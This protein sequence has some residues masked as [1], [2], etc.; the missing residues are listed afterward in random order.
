MEIRNT[1][2][3][4]KA[5]LGVSSTSPSLAQTRNTAARS[6]LEADQTTLSGAGS[7]ASLSAADDALRL[8]KV[9]EVRAALA[10]GTYQKPAEAV[11]SRL[12]DAMLSVDIDR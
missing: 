1:A 3:S 2:D 6:V 7:E 12:I 8:N 9:A 11:A 4:L 10:A 5:L